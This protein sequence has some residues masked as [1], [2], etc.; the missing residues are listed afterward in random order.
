M[1]RRRVVITGLGALTPIG[2]S[3]PE[4]WN[5]LISGKS[6]VR[7]IESFDASLFAT[8]FAAQIENYNPEDYFDKKT[9]RR[10]DSFCQYALIAS[11][12]AVKDS[13]INL[14]TIDVDRVSVLI[15]SGIGGF[16]TFHDQSK[17]FIER[18]PRGISPFFIPMLI[19]DIASGQVS[20]KYGFRGP[21]FCAVSACARFS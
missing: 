13:G 3:T 2:K 14:E 17:A 21:N 7:N 10:L 15:G 9:H 18:G 5:G 8:H 4:F 12:E 19:P 16:G 20:I 11:D 6:G 1:S